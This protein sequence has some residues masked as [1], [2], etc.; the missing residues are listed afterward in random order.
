[1]LKS[2][3]AFLNHDQIQWQGDPPDVTEAHIIVTILEDRVP[4]SP[5]RRPPAAIA[6]KGQTLGDLVSPIVAEQDWQCLK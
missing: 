1:M 5:R 3:E 2:Y 6:G 4:R